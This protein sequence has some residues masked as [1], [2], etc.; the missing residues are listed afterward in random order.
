MTLIRITPDKKRAKSLIKTANTSLKIIKNIDH[1]EFPSH[2]LKD[3]YEV[4]REFMSAKMLI[5]GFKTYG[6]GS[7]KEIIKYVEKKGYLS[8]IE[9]DLANKMRL[10]RNELVY[11]GKE[12]NKEFLNEKLFRI[13]KIIKKLQN[14]TKQSPLLFIKK[15]FIFKKCNI[16]RKIKR[17]HPKVE[18][19]D[20]PKL[21][22]SFLSPATLQTPFT[23]VS[24]ASVRI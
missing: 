19:K 8:F 24:A 2:V 5:D 12:I 14:L 13:K 22:C 10:L 3:Y 4:I 17:T 16:P 20:C 9:L 11:E 6:E 7:H 21:P 23:K 18:I 15:H 1:K